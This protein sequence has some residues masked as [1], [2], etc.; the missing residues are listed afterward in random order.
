M[1]RAFSLEWLRLNV[2][3][4]IIGILKL[5]LVCLLQHSVHL[6][7]SA[8]QSACSFSAVHACAQNTCANF[9]CLSSDKMAATASTKPIRPAP[10]SLKATV[11]QHFEFHEVK[12]WID[13]TYTVCKLC[14]AQL[15]YFD[16]TTHLKNH[17][18][19]YHSELGEK[20]RPVADA[21]QRRA[22]LPPN[23]ERAKRITKSIASFTV[24]D[25]RPYSVVENVGFRTMVFT[26]EPRCKIPSLRY[27]T[28]VTTLHYTALLHYSETK[29]EVFDTWWKLVGK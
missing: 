5:K 14:G 29:R 10:T 18:K 22:Q 28:T 12:G 8:T 15:K 1:H 24:L 19:W 4:F 2:D 23:S 13:K 27:F 11:W 25:L 6:L 20:Q 9:L 17:L 16:N 26:Q 21:S 7:Q 3:K